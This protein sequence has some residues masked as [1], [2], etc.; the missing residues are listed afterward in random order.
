MPIFRYAPWFK[1]KVSSASIAYLLLDNFTTDEAAPMS[2][3]RTCEPGPGTVEIS[4]A[5][6][7]LAISGSQ[8]AHST[9]AASTIG[10][11]SSETGTDGKWVG[12]RL[13][14][15]SASTDTRFGYATT[16]LGSPI[17]AKAIR[18]QLSGASASIGTVY[19]D[20]TGYGTV[21]DVHSFPLNIGIVGNT[22]YV[23]YLVN[24]KLAFLTNRGPLTFGY[25]DIVFSAG[26]NTVD[27]WRIAQLGAP[28]STNKGVATQEL[29][30]ARSPGDTFTH[31]ADCL[32]TA[33]ITTVPSADQ[34][35]L[36]FRVQDTSNYWQ[37]TVDNTGALDLD[38]V[39]AGTPTNRATA[40][41]VVTN[42][43]LIT[44][45]ATSSSIKVWEANNNRANYGSATNFATET[46]GEL[47]TEG[48]GGS[49]SNIISWPYTLSG[50]ALTELQQYEDA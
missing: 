37:V 6:N 9:G 26:N 41:A 42:G 17:T 33:V 7:L 22:S 39:V 43:E 25:P 45:K 20:N 1:K 11:N 48:T 23:Y 24:E 49:V 16:H 32:I 50:A 5:S 2:T 28:W 34:I 3:P 4:D 12:C 47:E 38:E 14:S 46:D 30:G 19:S 31:E 29:S 27:N 18:V 36:R 10:R 8:L 44:I 13:I 40:A 15:G 21:N 35:E